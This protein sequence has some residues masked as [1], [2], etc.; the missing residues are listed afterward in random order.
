MLLIPLL[1]SLAASAPAP[2]P[3]ACSLLGNEDLE[4]VLGSKITERKPATQDARGLLLSQCYIDT[5]TSRSVSIAVAG[6][7]K[8][9]SRTISPRQFW[10]EQF[11]P[12]EAQASEGKA[13]GRE[14]KEE[15]ETEARP[16][17]GVGD[18]AF[19]SS[20]RVAGALYVLTGNTFIRVSVG[21]IRQ[22]SERIEK[23]RQLALSAIARLAKAK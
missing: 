8:A 18:E 19:W 17:R 11:H 5:G 16:I 15:Q 14:A 13:E 9:G 4:R 7:T 12:R 20:T 3:D 10:R 23:S 1:I 21:G 2:A 22:E 6:D